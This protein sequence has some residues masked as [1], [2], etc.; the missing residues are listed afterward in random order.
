MAEIM[1]DNSPLDL[2]ALGMDLAASFQPSWAKTS[3]GPSP[4]ADHPGEDPRTRT[5]RPRRDFPKGSPR[6][7]GGK[8]DRRDGRRSLG[9]K[10]GP[11]GKGKPGNKGDRHPRSGDQPAQQRPEPQLP[12]WEVVFSPDPRGMEGVAKQ[13]RASAKAYPLFDLARLVLAGPERYN[14]TLKPSGDQ[15]APLFLFQPDQTLWTSESAAVRHAVHSSLDRFYRREFVEV[16]APKGSFAFVAECEGVLLGPPNHHEYQSRLR[17]LHAEKFSRM[18][19][20]AFKSRVRMLRDEVSINRWKESVSR[21]EVF[22]PLDFKRDSDVAKTEESA[23]MTGP[24]SP[25]PNSPRH[26]GDNP[27]LVSQEPGNQPESMTDAPSIPET[28]STEAASEVPDEVANEASSGAPLAEEAHSEAPPST[29]APP[30]KDLDAV[31]EH[32]RT[33]HAATTIVRVT[34]EI[35]VP[36]SAV[37]RVSS[38]PVVALVRDC[39][40]KLIRFP[41]ALSNLIG[42]ELAQ[43]GLQLFKAHQNITY[44]GIAR[45]RPTPLS[46]LG[47][48]LRA[49]VDVLNKQGKSPRSDLW[50]ALLDSRPIPTG[51]D[52]AA[53]EHAVRAD[54]SWLLHEGHVIDYASRGFE[55]I[56]ERPPKGTNTQLEP[57]SQPAR[58]EGIAG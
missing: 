18:P 23:G 47:D 46:Q 34:E 14:V 49:L 8:P 54:L 10:R 19:F 48:S 36:G 24:E 57:E 21:Q 9:D 27:N 53:R 50:Q 29:T 13:I 44:A 45:P 17:K 4:F 28:I 41:L 51:G 3:P 35:T 11:G 1:S 5:D 58:E 6:K 20:D 56:P 30:L 38:A 39:R 25:G 12:G 37:S 2:T 52:E 16:G 33:H 32:F 43:R 42:H 15:A 40:E 22:Y 26:P 55:I 31:I 7:D